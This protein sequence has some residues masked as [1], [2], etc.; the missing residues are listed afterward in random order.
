[1]DGSS[2]AARSRRHRAGPARRPPEPAGHPDGAR[3]HGRR[4]RGHRPG[5]LLERRVLGRGD[6]RLLH[7]LPQRGP[8]GAAAHLPQADAE[9]AGC[10]CCCAGRTCSATAT[11]RTRSSTASWTSRP[12]TAWTSSASSTPSTTCATSGGRSPRSAAR[13]STPQGT[14]CYTDVAR[15][16]PSRASSRWPSELMD[17]GCDS[18]CIKD[19]A[20]LLKPQPAY[21]IVRAIKETCGE[22]TLV[23]VHV[24]RH[25]RRHPGQ[26]DEGDRGRRRRRGHR[27]SRRS[28]SGP[29]HNPTEALVEMLEGHRL[30]D[31]AGRR[32]GC[33]KIK[34]HF[35][36]VRPR[37][38]EFDVQVHRRRDRDLRQPDPRRHDLEHGEP[39]Q[40]AGRRRPAQGGARR[41]AEGPQG[42]RLPAAGHAVQPDRRHPGRVQRADGPLQGADRR[43]RRPD[44][45]LLRRDARPSATPTIVEAA[46]PSTPR[47]SR[48]RAGRPTC[49]SPSGTSCAPRPLAL[50]GCDGTDED[51][52]TYAMFPQVAPEVLRRAG[53]GPEERRQGPGRGGRRRARRGR[54][55][56]PPTARARSTSPVPTRSGRRQVA[57]GH[58]RAGLSRGR[59]EQAPMSTDTA[60]RWRSGSPSC[61]SSG[62]QLEQGGGADRLAKQQRA[63]QADRPRADRRAGRPGQLRGDRA[64][65]PAPPDLLRHG[66][67]GG[68]RRRRGHRR[69]RR[70]TAGSSTSPA[71]TS[72]SPAARAGEVHS[73]QGRR[74]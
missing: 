9:L 65:R 68:P 55:P 11:T 25:H 72:R 63:G 6:L 57:Q 45:R 52:L 54:P 17:L 69:R 15:C 31:P 59:R 14:I 8:V 32:T 12:R 70:A 46:R 2:G 35:A 66:R 62:Q 10:R 34:D 36:K 56:R 22:D 13:A 71:R 41:G 24:P 51:V 49:S 18:I 50:E 28:A 48:S 44:A 39:A 42:R 3:G 29:G 73:Q 23:H 67:Q 1:M 30:H 16:T 33:C 26:P 58:R 53:R 27:R 21:D 43:V 61:A 20:A 19:M 64:V 37:Y 7:P 74:R 60:R 4:L 5:R 47:R 38:A 40:P